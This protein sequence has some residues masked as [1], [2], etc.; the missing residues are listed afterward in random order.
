MLLYLDQ[1]MIYKFATKAAKQNKKKATKTKSRKS[2]VYV[3]TFSN[4]PARTSKNKKKAK[5]TQEN[6]ETR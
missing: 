3:R 6:K 1:D 2:G 5:T 4:A